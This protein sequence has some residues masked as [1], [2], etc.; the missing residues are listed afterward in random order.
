MHKRAIICQTKN[1][2][3]HVATSVCLGDVSLLVSRKVKEQ[4]I[5]THYPH[6][7]CAVAVY[8]PPLFLARVLSYLVPPYLKGN[9]SISHC[10]CCSSPTPGMWHP[11]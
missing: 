10:P 1:L 9:P 7:I 2:P 6:I 3:S 4:L 8:Q 5:S 11:F